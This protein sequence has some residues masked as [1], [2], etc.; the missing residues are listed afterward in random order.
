MAEVFA[1]RRSH[2]LFVILSFFTALAAPHAAYA[3]PGDRPAT[4]LFLAPTGRAL[5][6]GQGYF[7]AV[8]MGMPSWQ[9]GITDRV[10]M[11]LAVPIYGLGHVAVVT[12]KVQVQRSEKHSTSIGGVGILT[13]VGSFGIAYVAHTIERETGAVHIAV[14]KPLNYFS[15]IRA[16]VFMLGAE[17]H[18]SD[19][20]TVMT[21]NYLFIGAPPILSG[22]FRIRAPHTTWDLGLLVP[23]AVHY[24]ARATPMVN[25]GY[26]F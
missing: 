24:G 20:V 14:M 6:K 2:K 8:G 15:E 11:G 17:H 21:E 10:S 26:K 16:T 4:Q 22:G 12:P 1:M 13:T 3:Q 23:T 7:K 25:V 19:R 18:V 9:G 5:P